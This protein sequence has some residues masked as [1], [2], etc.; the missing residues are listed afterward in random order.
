MPLPIWITFNTKKRVTST[1]FC[2]I[3]TKQEVAVLV[4]KKIHI[5]F[6][7]GVGGVFFDSLP[8]ESLSFDEQMAFVLALGRLLPQIL[9]IFAK[10]AF[11]PFLP[12]MQQFQRY[13]RG[14]YVEVQRKNW[15]QFEPLSSSTCCLI[16]ALDL[17]LFLAVEQNLF[18]CLYRQQL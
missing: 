16:V 5:T 7:V 8:H 12:E 2:L 18:S 14:R 17:A 3:A 9:K 6:V 10:N 11:R 1:F 4:E 15:K 13:R